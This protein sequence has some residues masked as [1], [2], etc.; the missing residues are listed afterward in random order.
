MRI[1]VGY[2]GLKNIGIHTTNTKKRGFQPKIGNLHQQFNTES[3]TGAPMISNRNT[4]TRCTLSVTNIHPT[5]GIF[6]IMAI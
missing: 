6:T 3:V 1:C 5:M 2:V 4:M